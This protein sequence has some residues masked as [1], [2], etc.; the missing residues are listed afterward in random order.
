MTVT[1]ARPDLAAHAAATRL[2]PAELVSELR[3]ILGARLVA[4]LGEVKETRAV[5][6]WADGERRISNPQ[7]AQ[8]LRIAYQ[9][10]KMLIDHDD[11]MTVQAWFLGLNPMLDDRSPARVLTDEPLDDAGP[12]ILAAARHFAATG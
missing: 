2:D 3:S 8:R 9:A 12:R 1:P 11:A 10:A 6:Q 4:Y 7:T 5:R